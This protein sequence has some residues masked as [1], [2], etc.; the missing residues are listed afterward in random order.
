[1]ENKHLR[2][3]CPEIHQ[4]FKDLLFKDLSFPGLQV[5]LALAGDAYGFGGCIRI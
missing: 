1:M 3:C 4:L 2:A 5:I